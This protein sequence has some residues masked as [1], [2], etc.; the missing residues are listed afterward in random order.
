MNENEQHEKKVMG[1][2]CYRILGKGVSKRNKRSTLPEVIERESTIRGRLVAQLVE[3]LT[4][5]LSPG[6][7]SVL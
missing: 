4:L 5:D 1:D 2:Y 7:I 3:R 6:L